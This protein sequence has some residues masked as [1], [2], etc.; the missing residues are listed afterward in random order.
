VQ[1]GPAQQVVNDYLGVSWNVTAER[2]WPD[3]REAPGDQIVRVRRVRVRDEG[4]LTTAA[5]DVRL[6][7]GIDV[8]YEVLQ[9]GHVLAPGVDLFNEEGVHLF[10][11]YDVG[12]EWRRRPRPVGCYTSTMW[13]PG[14]CLAEGNLIANVS[15]ASHIPETVMHAHVRNAVSFQAS[16]SREGGDSA[17]GD[18]TG[19]ISGVVR[20]W[21]DWTTEAHPAAEKIQR[22]PEELILK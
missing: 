21:L 3:S 2:E 5:I 11:A 19:P 7:V 13:I 8:V 14:N 18:R 12:E 17:R 1:D 4:G 6:Y 15:I 16:E 20:P 22:A 10:S 9:P